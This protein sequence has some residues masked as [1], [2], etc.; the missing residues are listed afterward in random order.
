MARRFATC[1]LVASAVAACSSESDPAVVAPD[2][3]A[4]VA[5]GE[6]PPPLTPIGGVAPPATTP[7]TTAAPTTV[8]PPEITGTVGEVARGNRVVLVGDTALATL[9]TRQDG[10]GCET[11]ADIGWQTQ[12]EAERGRF[13]AFAS[14]VLDAVSVDTGDDWDVVGLMFGHHIDTGPGEFRTALEELLDR[15]SPRP[16]VLYTIAPV[17][18]DGQLSAEAVALNGEIRTAA[19][20]RPNVALVDWSR[21]IQDEVDAQ[22]LDDSFVPT[23]AG[24]ERL[25]ALTAEV[26]G[27][28][29]A[30]AEG[31]GCLESVFTDDSA[32]LI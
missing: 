12:I 5:I 1:A 16:V 24:M 2:V 22:L 14:V 4:T 10:T 30:S 19:A 25:T 27:D 11:L 17:T 9:T 29:P 18:I 13:L 32:I 28:A 8:P 21:T 6:L 20:L 23:T 15:L 7:P 3:P 31:G 26:L